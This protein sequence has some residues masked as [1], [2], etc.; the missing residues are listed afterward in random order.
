MYDWY[1]RLLSLLAIVF[2]ISNLVMS[3]IAIP[4]LQMA[5]LLQS[6]KNQIL[7]T[8]TYHATSRKKESLPCYCWFQ[9]AH[10]FKVKLAL[11]KHYNMC[12]IFALKYSASAFCC[13]T[14][15]RKPGNPRFNSLIRQ[16]KAKFPEKLRLKGLY[17]LLCTGNYAL[18]LCMLTK[19]VRCPCAS[20]FTFVI[21]KQCK[22]KWDMYMYKIPSHLNYACFYYELQLF[23]LLV[24]YPSVCICLEWLLEIVTEILSTIIINYFPGK[25]GYLPSKT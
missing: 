11:L 1:C 25:S 16:N 13:R 20:S 23:I 7:V 18:C 8:F 24:F 5:S 14:F 2:M 6:M 21:K 10:K 4:A 22:P 15:Q 3:L 9:V 19:L 17:C 12:L